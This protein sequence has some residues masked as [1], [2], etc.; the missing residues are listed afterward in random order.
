MIN[1]QNSNLI[2]LP[3][4]CRLTHPSPAGSH[5][6]ARLRPLQPELSHTEP[7]IPAEQLKLGR[8]QR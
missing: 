7:Q 1:F 3:F 5:S 4:C 6:H 8:P 2:H